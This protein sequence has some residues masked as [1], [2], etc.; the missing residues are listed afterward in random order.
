LSS[1]AVSNTGLLHDVDGG[2]PYVRVGD[3]F[4]QI[5]HSPLTMRGAIAHK[6]G[7]TGRR[8]RLACCSACVQQVSAPLKHACHIGPAFTALGIWFSSS[9][10]AASRKR[11][12]LLIAML[13]GRSHILRHAMSMH[14]LGMSDCTETPGQR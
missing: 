5:L 1:G 8:L 9:D 14:L 3:V 6:G 11:L 7:I 10:Q 4:L 13:Y 2:L 12:G